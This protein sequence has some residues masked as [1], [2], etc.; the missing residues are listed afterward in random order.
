MEIDR[1]LKR[2]EEGLAC[3]NIALD[4]VQRERFRR[5]TQLLLD[6]NEKLSLTSITEPERIAIE[7]YLDSVAPLAFNLIGEEMAVVDV[8][9]GAGFPGLPLAIMCPKVSF[10]LIDAT[11]KK[12]TYLQSVC[13][14]LGLTNVEVV[15]GRAEELAHQKVFREGFDVAV[16]R[17]FG[18]LDIV[19][20][21]TLPFVKIGGIAIAYKGPKVDEELEIGELTAPLVGGKVEAVHRFTLP[22]SDLRRALVVAR[23]FESTQRRFPRRPG[24]PEKRPLR[25]LTK[26][27][28]VS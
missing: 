25:L 1:T 19:W 9:T 15:W 17:A 28:S 20:E 5:L 12:V 23:K 24:I 3:W 10:T 8:G 14:E 4:E 7:H 2:L 21:C 13:S 27:K 11:R 18:A 16:A 22:T 26:G 6:W